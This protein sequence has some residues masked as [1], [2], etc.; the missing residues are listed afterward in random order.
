MVL[1]KLKIGS[2]D[3]KIAWPIDV[4]QQIGFL[5]DLKE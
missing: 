2:H 4:S 1:L 5:A 3:E